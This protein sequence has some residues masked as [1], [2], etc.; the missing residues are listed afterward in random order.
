MLSNRNPG[1][2]EPGPGAPRAGPGPGPAGEGAGDSARTSGAPPGHP[3]APGRFANWRVSGQGKRPCPDAVPPLLPSFRASKGRVPGPPFLGKRRRL[4]PKRP[5][6]PAPLQCSPSRVPPPRVPKGIHA[7]SAGRGR[8]KDPW[9]PE[10]G[11]PGGATE[12]RSESLGDAAQGCEEA[13][14]PLSRARGGALPAGKLQSRK[15]SV[16]QNPRAGRPAPLPIPIHPARPV[17]TSLSLEE[18]FERRAEDQS[19]C[20]ERAASLRRRELRA[21]GSVP[22]GRGRRARPLPAPRPAPPRPALAIHHAAAPMWARPRRPRAAARPLSLG[23]Q[24]RPRG[25]GTRGGAEAVGPR[26]PRGPR[27]TGRAGQPCATRGRQRAPRLP[28]E[29]SDPSG[30]TNP[31]SPF[32]LHCR[33]AVARA[34]HSDE[35]PAHEAA[36]PLPSCLGFGGTATSAPRGPSARP[37]A[38]H[39]APARR[40]AASPPSSAPLPDDLPGLLAGA[41]GLRARR[42]QD[43]RPPGGGAA[44]AVPA[45]LRALPPRRLLGGHGVMTSFRDEENAS[46]SGFPTPCSSSALLW[47]YLRDWQLPLRN[48]FWMQYK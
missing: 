28:P 2:F 19:R 11:P 43:G 40:P 4:R 32:Q 31:R 20:G 23:F 34:S 47:G 22:L 6:R 9:A 1:W 48:I 15:A 12:L 45:F 44:A 18:E 7:P 46:S 17:T 37:R 3:W 38:T 14:A 41:G 42:R 35:S 29:T 39:P 33:P 21:G 25:V 13:R 26:G 8:N 36:G 27:D 5:S 16:G 24:R 30:G 10:A